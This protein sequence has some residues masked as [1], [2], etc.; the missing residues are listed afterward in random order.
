MVAIITGAA[1]A[2]MVMGRA[3]MA[4]VDTTKVEAV[5]AEWAAATV[6]TAACNLEP[7]LRL[8]FFLTSVNLQKFFKFQKIIL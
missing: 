7:Q 1:K 8:G 6:P 3:A 4:V 5:A 2:V